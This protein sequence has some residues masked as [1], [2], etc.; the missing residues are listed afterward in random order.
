MYK[1]LYICIIIIYA[2]SYNIYYMDSCRIK[3]FMLYIN[4]Y[5]EIYYMEIAR[6]Y[7]GLRGSAKFVIYN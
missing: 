5:M 2:S 4:Y 6:Q 1:I 3:I 7:I